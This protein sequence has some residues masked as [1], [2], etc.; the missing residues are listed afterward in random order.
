MKKLNLLLI[1]VI[2]FIT[3]L[4][5][6][7]QSSLKPWM[8]VHIEEHKSGVLVSKVLDD[9]P[10]MKS[11]LQPGDI[12]QKIDENKVTTPKEVIEKVQLKGV[13]HNVTLQIINKAK[14]QKT[15]KLELVA[16]PGM[17][18]LA[19]KNLLNKKAPNFKV[20]V[21]SKNHGKEL[22]LSKLKGK[23]TLIEFWAT[24][25]GACMQAHPIV[26][27]FADENKGKINVLSISDESPKKIRKFLHH[28]MK[29]KI[30]SENTIFLQG[31]ESTIQKDYFVPALPMFLVLDKNSKIQ[32]L[33]IGTG[34]N[35]EAAFANA[36]K[37]LK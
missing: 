3:P 11:G 9:T 15:L 20:K 16:M 14:Q 29:T 34:S 1:P 32:F 2:L 7:A 28:G 17:L 12:I 25:C 26:S 37:L 23:P 36:K 4:F 6:N 31:A 30:I 21:L 24:W 35:L 10:A 8:G 22:E 19:K 27:K 13:G 33:T 18:E 5:S